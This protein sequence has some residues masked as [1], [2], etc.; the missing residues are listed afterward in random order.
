MRLIAI[1][2]AVALLALP[3]VVFAQD[4]KQSHFGVIASFSPESKANDQL[5][6]V[7]DVDRIDVHSHDFEI[8]FIVRGRELGGDWGV[9]YVQKDY[10]RGSVL[11]SSEEFCQ[12]TCVK[13]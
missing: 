9:S 6:I 1:L 7:F 13:V 10:R 11:D 4:D 5:K 2:T 12:S 3:T 8:G